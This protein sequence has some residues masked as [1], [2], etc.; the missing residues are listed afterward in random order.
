MVPVSVLLPSFYATELG[1]GF[2]ATGAILML[3]R[4][5][6]L[7]TDPLIG[8]WCDR[9]QSRFGRRRPFM[10]VGGVIAL[11][12]LFALAIP[13]AKVS[14]AWL[15]G[16]SMLLYLG[17]TLVAIPYQTL[18]AE[19]TQDYHERSRLT[20]AREFAG[21]VGITLAVGLPALASRFIPLPENPL[22][23]VALLTLALGLPG[24]ALFFIGVAEPAPPLRAATG[25]IETAV[26]AARLSDLLRDCAKMRREGPF[27]RLLGAWFINGLANGLPAVL[28]PVFL[29]EVLGLGASARYGFLSLYVVASIVGLPLWIA[30]ARRLGKHHAWMLAM[31]LAS[32]GFAPALFLGQGDAVAFGA[33]CILTGICLGADLALP[34]AMQADVADL[35]RHLNGRDRTALLFGW[36]SLSAKFAT[37]LA[38]GIAFGILG[39]GS[40]ALD[41]A[42]LAS[43]GATDTTRVRWLYAG[44]PVALK[45]ISV[46]MLRGYPLDA[47]RVLALHRGRQR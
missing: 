27:F 30:L 1:L 19:L 44:V 22:L 20:G 18:A 26:P 25:G 4:L 12:A 45:L 13:T 23:P 24:F 8:R 6:D 46:L 47:D 42:S 29:S 15:L 7:F 10:L 39:S 16:F 31:L 37:A 36:W 17:W 43:A 40:G 11:L 33:I 34:P 32:L 2:A 28:L 5:S 38:V 35:D 41:A 9:T 3:A 21:L 14:L